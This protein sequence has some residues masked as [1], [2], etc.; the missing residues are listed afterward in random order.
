[1]QTRPYGRRNPVR[2]WYS[3]QRALPVSIRPSHGGIFHPHPGYGHA[4]FTCSPGLFIASEKPDEIIST[5]PVCQGINKILWAWAQSILLIRIIRQY[6]QHTEGNYRSPRFRR[7]V[8][9]QVSISAAT[10]SGISLGLTPDSIYCLRPVPAGIN[11]PTMTFSLSPL[12]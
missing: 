11:L 12:R 3:F 8:P 1:L 2:A 4:V 7:I 10:S 9:S 6:R 5:V